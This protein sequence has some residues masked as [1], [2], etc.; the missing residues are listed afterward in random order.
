MYPD[1]LYINPLPDKKNNSMTVLD[2]TAGIPYLFQCII[3]E[4]QLQI[5]I[6]MRQR[7]GKLRKPKEKNTARNLTLSFCL[8][9]PTKIYIS[10]ILLNFRVT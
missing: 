3:K 5:S 4:C 6:K 8:V 7:I 10:K 2:L 1:V 9:R